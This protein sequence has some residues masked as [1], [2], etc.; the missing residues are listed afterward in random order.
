MPTPDQLPRSKAEI[1]FIFLFLP[2]VVGFY[3]IYKYP[4]W[5]ADELDAFYLFGKQPA[6]WYGLT[7]TTLVSVT[8]L[9]ILVR[10]RNAYSIRKE[11][12]PLNRYQKGKFSMILF[13]QLCAFFLVPFVIIPLSRGVDFWHDLPTEPVKSAHV[14]LWPAFTSLGT[15]LYVFVLITLVVYFFG[16]RYCSWFC[17]CGNLAET[18][19]VTPWGRKWVMKYT[20]RG[21]GATKL[22]GV[23]KIMMVLALV[24]GVILFTDLMKLA[25]VETIVEKSLSFQYFV[26]DL[27]FGSIIG[28]GSYPFLGTRIWCRYGCPLASW[29]HWLGPTI[30]TKFRVVANGQCKGIGLCTK[31]CPMGIMVENYAHKDKTPIM[32]TFG[33]K[34][35]PC[36][37]CGGC[38]SACPTKALSFK[39]IMN[40]NE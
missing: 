8:C 6:F 22:E 30:K 16:K 12:E 34:E 27:I 33:L 24:T 36:I 25:S 32:G 19:G 29:M 18:V 38:I 37:G 5:F 3:L 17:S 31:T 14:Y 26:T 39:N 40:K 21:E 15:A 10:G 13:S 28:V 4:L 11:P 20:P 1:I 7:Y 35:T 23:Q 2:V 9:Y